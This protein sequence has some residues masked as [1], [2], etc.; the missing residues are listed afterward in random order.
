MPKMPSIILHAIYIVLLLYDAF[1]FPESYFSHQQ[2]WT[3]SFDSYEFECYN[4]E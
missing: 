2:T 4:I 1:V 3:D